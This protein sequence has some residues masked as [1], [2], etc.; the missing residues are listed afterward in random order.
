MIGLTFL[1]I[2]LLWLAFSVFVGRKLPRWLGIRNPA[3]KW[4]VT[5]AA[6]AVL[7]I[8]PFVDEIVGMRQF[9]RLCKE[10]AVVWVGPGAEKVTAAKKAATKQ[11]DLSG[12]WI[13][14]HSRKVVY[15]DAASGIPFLGYETLSTKGGRIARVALLGGEHS[16]RPPNPNAM[17]Y[18][19][20]DKLLEEGKT[21]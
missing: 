2:G 6:V 3:G 18:L 5:V 17:N 12:Y 20:I 15:L 16:C 19:N 11:E 21:K 1:A 9:E 14:I 4:A 7:L 13:P 10:R 8:G